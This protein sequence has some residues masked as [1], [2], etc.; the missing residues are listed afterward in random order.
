MGQIGNLGKLNFLCHSWFSFSQL[1]LFI[2]DQISWVIKVGR[3]VRRYVFIVDIIL[4]FCKVIPLLFLKNLDEETR[5]KIPKQISLGENEI[6]T[7]GV[8]SLFTFQVHVVLKLTLFQ[9]KD[10][11]Q[12]ESALL[13]PAMM[14]KDSVGHTC[15]KQRLYLHCCA[16]S[17]EL[18]SPFHDTV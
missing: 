14:I 15:N 5:E 18:E 16:F 9:S 12:E 17:N 10:Q 4:L 13:R 7:P 3:F 1:S 8:F 6:Q 11:G 2:P